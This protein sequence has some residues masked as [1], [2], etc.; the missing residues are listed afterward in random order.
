[1]IWYMSTVW[2]HLF[3]PIDS[4]LVFVIPTLDDDSAGHSL[5]PGLS[6]QDR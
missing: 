1:M 2:H 4:D 3:Q 6:R 5:A